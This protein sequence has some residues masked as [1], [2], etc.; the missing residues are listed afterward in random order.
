MTLSWMTPNCLKTNLIEGGNST[1]PHL[2]FE[3]PH[4]LA[5]TWTAFNSGVPLKIAQ[6]QLVSVELQLD[7]LSTRG[8][9]AKSQVTSTR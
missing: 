1:G 9:A 8:Q 6:N 7:N 2:L 3:M 5:G 4:N